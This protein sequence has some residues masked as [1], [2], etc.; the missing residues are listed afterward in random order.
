MPNSNEKTIKLL[1]RKS[2][3]ASVRSHR[4]GTIR[5]RR[6]TLG[7]MVFLEKLLD[8][9]LSARDF[10][11]K[12]IEHQVSAPPE[13]TQD[14]ALWKERLL[15]R[16]ANAWMQAEKLSRNATSQVATCG[17]FKHAVTDYVAQQHRQMQAAIES[18]ER[19]Y[20]ETIA[21][22]LNIATSSMSRLSDLMGNR[23]D[24]IYKDNLGIARQM[25]NAFELGAASK[26]G[27]AIARVAID[28]SQIEQL[29]SVM[30]RMTAD[31]VPPWVEEARLARQTMVDSLASL[32]PAIKVNEQMDLLSRNI[33]K[34]L[35]PTDAFQ[36]AASAVSQLAEAANMAKM[37]RMTLLAETSLMKVQPP[38]FASLLNVEQELRNSVRGAFSQFSSS[39]AALYQPPAHLLSGSVPSR[40]VLRLPPVEYF[41]GAHLLESISIDEA[42][43][44][45]TPQQQQAKTDIAG[46]TE[47]SLPAL[48]AQVNPSLVRL[49]R[50]AKQA[51]RSDN[52]DRV[53]HFAISIRELTTQV[54]H[55]LAP[56]DQIRA[57]SNSPDQFYQGRP[58][59]R[60]RLQ[61]IYRKVTND[62]FG[63]FVE[64]DI[65]TSLALLD[66]FQTGTHGV[67]VEYTPAQLDAMALKMDALIRFI[68]EIS[69]GSG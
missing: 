28:R 52:P 50:G 6:L 69:A 27:E 59:R 54:L 16:V 11:V 10:T 21:P 15:L 14:V 36:Q 39:F 13:A 66:L 7:D 44:D 57:W 63:G 60:A 65:T 62:K 8:D 26:I 1:I 24:A 41:T 33:Q 29:E 2:K 32:A 68:L 5:V 4:Y 38:D 42:V 51:L 67:A 43:R 30:T 64:S 3:P 46:E 37:S 19:S 35:I 25:D 56:D 58:T 45:I 20:R 47:E 12:L 61:F 53:R 23:L 18:V 55:H 17:E 40:N 34:Q 22:A 31:I 49:W 9:N 48:L